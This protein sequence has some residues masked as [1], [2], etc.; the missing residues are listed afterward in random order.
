MIFDVVSAF[1]IRYQAVCAFFVVVFLDVVLRI[2]DLAQ[3]ITAPEE[4]LFS[5]SACITVDTYP[6]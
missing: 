2:A 3:F 1:L 6:E 5:R 4:T